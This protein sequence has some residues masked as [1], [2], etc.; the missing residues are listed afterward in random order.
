[1]ENRKLPKAPLEE[2]IFELKW[3]LQPDKTGKQLV[4]DQYSFALGKFHSKIEEEF[5]FHQEKIPSDIPAQLLSYKTVHQFWKS[6]NEWPVIQIGP[7]ILTINETEK[8][9]EWYSKFHPLIKLVVN[10]LINSYNNINFKAVSLRYIDVVKAENYNF[11]NW[12]AFVKENINF[13][14]D[15]KFD[16]KGQL[17][18]FQF[19]QFFNLNELGELNVNLSNGLNNKK[20]QIFIWQTALSNGGNLTPSE[21]F[22]WVIKAHECNS[23]IFKDICKKEFYGSFSK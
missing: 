7:G 5:P 16:T 18:R 17:K 1:M 12:E 21:L 11:Q 4:D 19:D 8:N 6:N 10:H 20:E 15:N 13:N 2:V 9:Y 14:F 22:E 23:G 3:E